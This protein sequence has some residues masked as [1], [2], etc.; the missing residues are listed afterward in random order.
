M[1]PKTQTHTP[2][3]WKLEYDGSIRRQSDNV[4]LM[5]LP[6]S[7]A[8]LSHEQNKANAAFIVRAVNAHEALIEALDYCLDRLSNREQLDDETF[9]KY[10]ALLIHAKA[11]GR[12]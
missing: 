7:N 4:L 8:D 9:G 2:T 5:R 1:T 10:E 3:P 11:E 6:P 12:S